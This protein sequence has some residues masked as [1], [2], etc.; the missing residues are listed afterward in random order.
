MIR[1]L[2]LSPTEMFRFPWLNEKNYPRDCF[3]IHLSKSW[4]LHFF[5]IE[6]KQN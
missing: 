6:N 4:A 3:P 5:E 1:Q 2:T